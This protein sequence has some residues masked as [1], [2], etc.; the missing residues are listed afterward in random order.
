MLLSEKFF[1]LLN[2]DEDSAAI[3][4]LYLTML[5]PMLIFCAQYDIIRQFLNCFEKSKVSMIII[6]TTTCLHSVWCYIFVFVFDLHVIGV[7][8]ATNLTAFLNLVG[9]TTYV[10]FF[11]KDLQDAWF[12]PNKDCFKGILEYMKLGVPAMLMVCFEWWVFEI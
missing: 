8:M 2:V 11:E 7:A 10:S 3:G 4:Q 12:W 9:L 6:I 5:I 1:I